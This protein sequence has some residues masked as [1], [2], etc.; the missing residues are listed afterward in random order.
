MNAQNWSYNATNSTFN[1]IRNAG[2]NKTNFPTLKDT[3]VVSEP[4][5][6]SYFTA[7]DLH[8]GGIDFLEVRTY[9]FLSPNINQPGSVNAA[10]TCVTKNHSL[11]EEYA[12]V[13]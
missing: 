6:A 12:D 10:L 13:E 4:E 11:L 2:F 1:A 3:I 9:T 7:R 8:E 5:A